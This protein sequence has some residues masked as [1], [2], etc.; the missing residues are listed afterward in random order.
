MKDITSI[1]QADETTLWN[2]LTEGNRKAL[3]IIYQRYYLLLLNYGLK[4]TSDRELIKDCIHDLFVH[5]YLGRNIKNVFI[6]KTDTKT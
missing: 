6:C 4:C 2:L 5:L 3:E 1:E